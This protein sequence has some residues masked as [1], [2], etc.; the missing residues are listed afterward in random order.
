[1]K[2]KVTQLGQQSGPIAGQ[3]RKQGEVV[4]LSDDEAHSLHAAG[5]VEIQKPSRLD[6]LK[7]ADQEATD[8]A[9]ALEVTE[10]K[11]GDVANATETNLVVEYDSVHT[12]ANSVSDDT[13]KIV[14]T[15]KNK[16]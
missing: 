6:L 15:K 12:P 9:K 11:T 1:M 8:A 7:V 13:N 4:D 14:T 16:N 3:N 5:L 2:T 10:A